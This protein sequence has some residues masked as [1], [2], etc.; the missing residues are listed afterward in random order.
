M[1]KLAFALM[2]TLAFT[3]M[4][5]CGK[6]SKAKGIALM[7]NDLIYSS[8][9]T[10]LARL[11]LAGM[12]MQAW[13]GQWSAEASSEDCGGQKT[14]TLYLDGENYGS[15]PLTFECDK[16][17][18]YKVTVSGNNVVIQY[19]D[20]GSTRTAFELRATEDGKFSSL[21]GE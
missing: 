4:S 6:D 15:S 10:L 19:T 2:I 9:R 1:K 16:R 18:L 7:Y 13:T 3:T 11:E 20:G 8:G 12:S 17:N 5:G 14:A 21:S